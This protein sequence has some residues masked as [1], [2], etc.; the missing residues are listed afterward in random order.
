[1]I[2]VVGVYSITYTGSTFLKGYVQ[3]FASQQRVPLIKITKISSH[4]SKHLQPIK[5]HCSK[6]Q[7]TY[8]TP[9]QVKDNVQ[10]TVQTQLQC[11]M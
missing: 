8:C 5:Y 10:T 7:T 2:N 3:S 11:P 9:H 6:Q 4:N 1:L